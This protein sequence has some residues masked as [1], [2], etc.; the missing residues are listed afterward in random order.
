V[1]RLRGPCAY[2]DDQ[3]RDDGLVGDDAAAV[4][5]RWEDAGAHWAV[6]ARHAGS[7]TVGLYRCDGGEEVDRITS[8]DPRLDEFLAGRESSLE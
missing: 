3:P 6:I 2:F 8:A 5:Q 1:S 7:V 4:L